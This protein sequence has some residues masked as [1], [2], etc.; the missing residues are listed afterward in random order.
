M[1]SERVDEAL[2]IQYLLGELPDAEQNRVED[3]AFTDPEYLGV[4]EA[5]ETDLID[6]YVMGRLNNERRV[7]FERRFL[8]SP[9]RRRKVEFARSLALVPRPAVTPAVAP[10]A[11][12]PFWQ[13]IVS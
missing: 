13:A 10:A 3:R 2:L 5:A 6:D 12:Q 4:I 7:Q 9:Q 11:R 8:N 1:R